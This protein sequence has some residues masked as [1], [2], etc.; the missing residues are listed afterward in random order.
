MGF[1]RS[2]DAAA[3][4]QAWREFVARNAALVDAAGLPPKVVD[5]VRTWDDVLVHGCLVADPHQFDL[6]QLTAGQYDALVQLAEN[7]FAAGYEFFAPVALRS[8]DQDG[9]RSRFERR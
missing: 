5:S 3:A 9:L 4:A 1:R 8:D 7:Y 6:Q 2:P